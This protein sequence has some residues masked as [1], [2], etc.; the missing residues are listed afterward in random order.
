MVA[1]SRVVCGGV[2]EVKGELRGHSNVYWKVGS[3]G[4]TSTLTLESVESEVRL[5][6]V[7]FLFFI[8]RYDF[9]RLAACILLK[10]KNSTSVHTKSEDK[11]GFFKR[12]RF[13]TNW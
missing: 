7:G 5:F 4:T 8:V 3:K 11:V 6:K 2:V 13:T 1:V 10:R 9:L 12:K